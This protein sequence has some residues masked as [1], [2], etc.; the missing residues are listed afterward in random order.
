MLADMMKMAM[1]M[2][3]SPEDLVLRAIQEPWTGSVWC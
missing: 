3:R 1:V 2:E